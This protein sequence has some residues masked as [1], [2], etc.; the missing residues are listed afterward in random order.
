M[1]HGDR[2]PSPQASEAAA[3]IKRKM[4][5]KQRKKQKQEKRRLEALAAA[6]EAAET[7]QNSAPESPGQV[8]SSSL[9]ME[10]WEWPRPPAL[11]SPRAGKAA[12][13]VSVCVLC[14]EGRV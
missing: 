14:W 1:S 13:K 8:E 4:E 3:E 5:K 12:P 7:M 6:A 10:G 9:F 2:P 11:K